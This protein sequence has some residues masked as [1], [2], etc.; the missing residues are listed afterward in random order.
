MAFGLAVLR[1]VLL[2]R[3]SSLV[4]ACQQLPCRRHRPAYL[5]GSGTGNELVGP[6][7]LVRPLGNLVGKA[8]AGV[9]GLASVKGR[10]CTYSLIGGSLVRV[11][12]E[13]THVC[14]DV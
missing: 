13:P 6:F 7:S 14:I 9:E 11:V 12:V 5:V 1:T 4:H 3:L 8:I 2:V 10:R